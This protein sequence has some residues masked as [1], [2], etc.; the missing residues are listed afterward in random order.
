MHKRELTPEERAILSQK[1]RDAWAKRKLHQAAAAQGY[2][3]APIVGVQ[4]RSTAD[5]I[6]AETPPPPPVIVPDSNSI[7]NPNGHTGDK[8]ADLPFYEA[9]AEL[10]A[11]EKEV[12][13]ARQ[14]MSQR[15]SMLPKVWT[16]WTALHRKAQS[17]LPGMH[18]TYTQCAKN[19]PDGKWVFKD[20]CN[21]NKDTGLID[22][23]VCC[24]NRC[25][26]LY[27]VFRS[28]EKYKERTQQ[29]A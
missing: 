26:M 22:P 28:R 7:A 29:T 18:S 24:S 2:Q 10:T 9:L 17:A 20:D 19:I 25:Y 11:L 14:I 13:H 21:I 6:R 1:M 8:W 15:S 4:P 27:Q 3:E 12:T 5:R 23:V 16:C